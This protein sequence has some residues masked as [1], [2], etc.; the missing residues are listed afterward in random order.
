MYTRL[1]GCVVLLAG[2]ACAD[3]INLFP[4][5][6]D[7]TGFTTSSNSNDGW[8]LGRG[9]VFQMTGDVT[10]DSLGVLI[11]ATNLAFTWEVSQVFDLTGY[12]GADGKNVL[13][14]GTSTASTN[15]L[16]FIDFAFAPVTLH[17]GNDYHLDISFTGVANQRFYYNNN[18][19]TFTTGQFTSLDGTNSYNTSNTVMPALRLD[20]V[21]PVPEPGT[22]P[23]IGIGITLLLLRW[24][25]GKR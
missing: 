3:I 19:V 5:P 7:P 6:N 24:R 9:M 14:S 13:A 12:V 22:L 21:A 17:A 16:Q 20:A 23:L 8:S 10:V 11:D 2:S 15:G 25:T 18:N 1:L 4:P